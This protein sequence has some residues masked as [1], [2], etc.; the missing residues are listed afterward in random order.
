MPKLLA[1]YDEGK[2]KLDELIRADYRLD[3]INRAFADLESGQN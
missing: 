3:Q 1:M 2:L